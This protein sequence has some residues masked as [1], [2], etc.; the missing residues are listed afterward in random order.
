MIVLAL[1]TVVSV[2]LGPEMYR[3]GYDEEVREQEA[4]RPEPAS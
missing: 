4:V 2:Y 1:I 3:R